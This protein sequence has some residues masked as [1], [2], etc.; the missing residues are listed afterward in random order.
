MEMNTQAESGE[1][2][3]SGGEAVLTPAARSSHAKADGGG[4]EHPSQ[5]ERDR[6][7]ERRSSADAGRTQKPR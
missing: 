3:V 1:T 5:V 2:S 7:V 4:D 6:R